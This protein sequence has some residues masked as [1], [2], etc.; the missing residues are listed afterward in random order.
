M[1]TRETIIS[2]ENNTVLPG[3]GL[4]R[5]SQ[6]TAVGNIPRCSLA[7]TK[8]TYRSF[9]PHLNYGCNVI[10]QQSLYLSQSISDQVQVHCQTLALNLT[11]KFAG[12]F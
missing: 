4:C 7:T 5:V 8:E 11:R 9:H 10:T 2:Y 6:T 3:P 1:L 12:F